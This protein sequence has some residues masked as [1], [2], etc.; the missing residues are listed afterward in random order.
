MKDFT[1]GTN[2]LWKYQGRVCVLAS[3]DLR[4]RI[5]A[6]A[7]KSNFTIHPSVTKMYQ[8]LKKIF[9]WHGMKKDIAKVV[10]RC[11][12]CQKLKN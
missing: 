1:K 9:L 7:H 4:E 12:V 10:S 3:D 8:D 5:M 6:E 11:L 2:G